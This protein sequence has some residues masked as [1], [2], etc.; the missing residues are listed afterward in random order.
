MTAPTIMELLAT[1]IFAAA[2]IHTFLCAQFQALA[3]RFREGS[4]AE[5]LLHLLG[6]VEVVFGLW[7]GVLII[8]MTFLHGKD[9]VITYTNSLNFTEPLFVLVIM[10]ICATR[11]IVALARQLIFTLSK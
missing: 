11:P 9:A 1:A 6:E 7:A 3:S 4:V 2:V 5:N 8:A 10:T